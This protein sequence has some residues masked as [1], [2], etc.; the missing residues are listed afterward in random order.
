[1]DTLD[2]ADI[3]TSWTGNTKEPHG[4]WTGQTSKSNRKSRHQNH[5]DRAHIRT[6][7]T[8][9]TAEPH[10]ESRH[11]NHM[12]KADIRAKW[13]EQAYEPHGQGRHKNAG[14]QG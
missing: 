1:M 4:H 7:C 3:R 11:K 2:R 6:T 5:M 8:G 14:V 12:D 10:R 9:Q 13:T